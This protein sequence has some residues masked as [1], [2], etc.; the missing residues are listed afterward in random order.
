ML[1]D[2]SALLPKFV[3]FTGSGADNEF[4]FQVNFQFSTA[5]KSPIDQLIYFL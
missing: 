4:L 1:L 5:D 3:D 2:C